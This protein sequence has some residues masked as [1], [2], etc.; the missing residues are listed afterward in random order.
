MSN[1]STL[2][3]TFVFIYFAILLVVGYLASR[4]QKDDDYLIAERKL[5]AFSTMAT[6]NASKTGS[7]IMLF[8]A[9]V[10]MVGISGIWYFAGMTLGVLMFIPFALRLKSYSHAT[11][12]TLA[13]YFKHNYGKTSGL[14]AGGMTIF[15]MFGFLVLNLMAATKIFI[16]FTGWPFW[17]CAIITALVV[18]IYLLMGGFKAVVKTDVIQYIAMFFIMALLA[19]MIFKHSLVSTSD[20]NLFDAKAGNVVGYFILGAFF[21]FAMPDLWQRV[22]SSKNKKTLKRGLLLSAIIYLVFALF[23]GIVALEIKTRFPDVDPDIALIHG[24]KNILS[25]GFVGLSVVLLFS[26]IMSSIDTYL[27]TGASAVVQD[28]LKSNKHQTVSRIRKVI[29][30]AAVLATGISILIQDLIVGAYFF[31]ASTIVL[32]VMSLATWIRKDIEERTL[33]FGFTFGL[34]GVF[35][36][37]IVNIIKGEIPPTVV[38]V[39]L[40]SSLLGLAVGAVV[41]L[42]RQ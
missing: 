12:Y 3:L 5:G 20:W 35:S 9:M 27:F 23:L 11:F 17:V 2:D 32:S 41:G 34:V 15:L 16:F 21:P 22:Y 29:F 40:V 10:Y 37:V 14:F 30:I 39:G 28:F 7:I 19:I 26:A 24:F 8:V 33:I 18:L 31:V 36:F 1:L 42:V 38:M 13:D 6:I 25:P 4:H